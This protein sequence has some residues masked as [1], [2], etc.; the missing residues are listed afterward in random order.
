MVDRKRYLLNATALLRAKGRRSKSF[1]QNG[2]CHKQHSG[3]RS[4]QK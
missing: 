2:E 1:L 4:F 3:I